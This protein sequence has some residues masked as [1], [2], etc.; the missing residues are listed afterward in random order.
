MNDLMIQEKEQLSIL[1]ENKAKQIKAAFNPMMEKLEQVENAYNDVVNLE[2]TPE[3][4]KVAKRMRL[5][6]SRIRIE[7]GKIKT[8]QKEEY[9]RAGKAI[10]G[11]FNI[12]KFAVVSK[13]EKLKDIELYYEKIEAEKKQKLQSDREGILA[14][15]NINGEFINLGDMTEDVWGNYLTGVK[16]NYEAVKEAERKA[17]LERIEAEEKEAEERAKIR[18]ENERLKI[19]AEKA[20]KKRIAEQKKLDIERKKQERKLKIEREKVE[21]EKRIQDEIIRKERE[22]KEKL[23]KEI[24]KKEAERLRIEKEKSERLVAE[25]KEKEN[26]PDKIKLEELISYME[27]IGKGL[28]SEEAK[29]IVR[30]SYRLIKDYSKSL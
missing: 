30:E 13:E 26:A 21:A 24:R 19:E 7:A 4:C 23:E 18:I 28:K 14:E 17:E 27:G 6:I 29:K 5:D 2:I 8:A 11:I 10:Q 22:A 1:T 12:I 9:N 16:N 25:Q 20:E 15:Y 3:T